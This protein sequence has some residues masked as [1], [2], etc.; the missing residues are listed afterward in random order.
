MA[1]RL[2]TA[3]LFVSVAILGCAA[4]GSEGVGGDGLED[5]AASSSEASTDDGGG[6]DS[7]TPTG[8]GAFDSGAPATVG[9][10]TDAGAGAD[11]AQEGGACATL[12][13]CPYENAPNVAGVACTSGACVI[14]CNGETY[15][16]NGVLSDGCE[17]VG[18][19]V[20]SQDASL[21]PVDDH[22]QALAA[23]VGSFS[24]DD[25]SSA[26]ALSGAV[27]SDFRTHLPAIDDFDAVTG[28]APDYFTIDATGGL[29]C[30]DDA[31]FTLT[32][33]GSKQ[34]SCYVLNLLTDKNGG[35]ACMTA[36]NGVCEIT[37]SSGSYSDGSTIYVWVSKNT[38]CAAATTPDDGTFQLT[39]HL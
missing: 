24:C 5:A 39:G 9:G 22:T 20:K 31:N 13:Q 37:N 11:G 18:D 6:G 27:P 23:S 38:T 33:T 29:T 14:T 25:T 17:V 10:G 12:A 4:S 36:G 2:T 3:A 8:S 34:P 19:C 28:A 30:Q 15:D 1:L 26:Q 7:A 21:C 32:V 16:V 35:Q